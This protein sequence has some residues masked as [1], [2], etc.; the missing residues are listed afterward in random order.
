[1][2]R[3]SR[4]AR[5]KRRLLLGGIG[6]AFGVLVFLIV[7]LCMYG[8]VKKVPKDK[9]ANNVYIGNEYV[10]VDVSGMTEK[11]AKKAIE[12][13][14]QTSGED[15]VLLI[16][17][18]KETEATLT[19]LGFEMTDSE[20][21][22]KEALA[23]GKEGSLFKR[24][25]MLRKLKKEKK[26]VEAEYSFDKKHVETFF[27]T[28]FEGLEGEAQNATIKRENNQFVITEGKAGKKID[29]EKSFKALQSY[30]QNEWQQTTNKRVS[31][32]IVTSE[33]DIKAEQLQSIKDQ[34]GTF[35]TYYSGGG[36]R[37]KNIARATTKISGALLMPG[38]E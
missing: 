26:I 6:L 23:Y 1:M 20:K 34:I 14:I 19:D 15:T 37:D 33:P 11:E 24:Y 8:T 31:L 4:R 16:A 12:E 17:E 30:V 32:T 9:I 7:F 25:S 35:K 28:G 10:S 18:G 22:V 36:N 38:D 2:R 5:M 29:L 21:L 3:R 27:E 13:Q